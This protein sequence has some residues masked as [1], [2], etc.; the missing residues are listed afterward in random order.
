MQ[1][2]LFFPGKI[3]DLRGFAP[4]AIA[5]SISFSFLGYFNGHS[6]SM[7]S[8]IQGIIQS[9][10]VRLPMAYLMSI[11]PNASLVG[12]GLAAP[13]STA[14]GIVMCLL[15]YKHMQKEGENRALAR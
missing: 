5:T 15:Y 1:D 12:I 6:K 9:F 8:M 2:R 10:L 3:F 7:F 13:A 11:Q 14:V 4:D